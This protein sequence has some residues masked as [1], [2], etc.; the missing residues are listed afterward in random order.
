MVGHVAFMRQLRSAYSIFVRKP[1]V[2][3]PLRR[4][5]HGW[6]DNIRM[7][8]WEVGWLRWAHENDEIIMMMNLWV[9][10]KSGSLLTS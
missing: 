2:K 10:L 8:L 3:R 5:R 6:V 4:P 7:D 1:E 9:P